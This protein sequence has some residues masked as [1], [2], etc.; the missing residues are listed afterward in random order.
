MIRAIGIFV[1]LAL[2]AVASWYAYD[3]GR[4]TERAAIEKEQNEQRQRT[5]TLLEQLETAKAKTRV[6]TQE[7]IRV[8]EKAVGNCWDEQV[9]E[10]D[11]RS[12]LIE[13]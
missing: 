9:T 11:D 8:I 10:P 2:G 12:A 5:A 7:R 13:G 3:Y 4:Q 6:I 1:L